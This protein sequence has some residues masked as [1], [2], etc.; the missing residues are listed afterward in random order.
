M[1][2]DN[3]DAISNEMKDKVLQAYTQAINEVHDEYGMKL[4]SRRNRFEG[5][6]E[7]REERIGRL[8]NNLILKERES[9]RDRKMMAKMILLLGNKMSFIVSVIS[10]FVCNRTLSNA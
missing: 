7:V 3:I 6:I 9:E 8:E 4:A 10:Y 5:E 1:L 2:S